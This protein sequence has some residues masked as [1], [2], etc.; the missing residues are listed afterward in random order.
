MPAPRPRH[1]KLKNAYSPRHARAMPAPRPRQCP[2]PPGAI[3]IIGHHLA[4]AGCGPDRGAKAGIPRSLAPTR[5][6]MRKL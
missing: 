6:K 1:P 5:D 4:R 3:R 2:V